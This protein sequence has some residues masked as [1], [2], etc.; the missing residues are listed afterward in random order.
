M[1]K[2]LKMLKHGFQ[3]ASTLTPE[4]AQFYRTFKSEF[5]KELQSI[6]ATEIEFYRLH[7]GLSGFFRVYGTLW[8]FS[9]SDVR[10]MFQGSTEDSFMNK[11]LYR[12]AKHNRDY[13]G[14][15]NRYAKIE[16]GMAENMCWSF[17]TIND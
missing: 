15:S 3:S 14:G 10:G 6:N 17:K 7:F 16:K 1:N 13:T 9:L 2:S 4:F 5:T 8:Y 12:T 11:M